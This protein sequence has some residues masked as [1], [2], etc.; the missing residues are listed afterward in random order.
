[1]WWGRR[2]WS[3][4][5]HRNTTRTCYPW[6]RT[7]YSFFRSDGTSPNI[8]DICERSLQ[9]VA[10]IASSVRKHARV[11][12]R[13]TN[14][15]HSIFIQEAMLKDHVN[16]IRRHRGKRMFSRAC[17]GPWKF[18]FP[19]MATRSSTC[20]A[21]VSV[22]V[23][24]H[25]ICMFRMI[26]VEVNSACSSW[27]SAIAWRLRCA[28]MS[29]RQHLVTFASTSR[30]GIRAS[31]SH[32][33]TSHWRAMNLQTELTCTV[34]NVLKHLVHSFVLMSN[35]HHE[36]KVQHVLFWQ[37]HVVAKPHQMCWIHAH[38]MRKDFVWKIPIGVTQDKL[39]FSTLRVP[40]IP[41]VTPKC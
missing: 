6:Q 34:H 32:D 41:M 36:V 1:M 35:L 24:C 29:S 8:G 4:E 3:R 33:L 19:W 12:W 16:G 2:H 11:V 15:S 17:T 5:G 40:L 7:D 22:V 39:T 30:S 13:R 9:N 37:S 23:I 14:S 18:D 31:A 26:D 38:W 28:I 27:G 20:C 21:S 25:V 10:L